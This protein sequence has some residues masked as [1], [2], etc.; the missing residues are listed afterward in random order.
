MLIRN[1]DAQEGYIHKCDDSHKY[2][3]QA[4]KER[5]PVYLHDITAYTVTE[6]KIKPLRYCPYCGQEIETDVY[7]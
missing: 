1:K 7:K 2:T 3:R 5:I 6:G 4:L